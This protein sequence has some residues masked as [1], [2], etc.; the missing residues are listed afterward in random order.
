MPSFIRLETDERIL[1]FFD[2]TEPDELSALRVLE[3]I[4]LIALQHPYL[5][6]IQVYSRQHGV[7]STM[8][9][10][11]RNR[12]LDLRLGTMLVDTLNSPPH[13]Y[14]SRRV[15]FGESSE[16]ENLFSMVIGRRVRNGE[17]IRAIVIN[18][19]ADIIL[20]I[21]HPGRRVRDSEM[22]I[23]GPNKQVY[24][25]PDSSRFSG[26]FNAEEDVWPVI[27]ADNS[28]GSLSLE[29]DGVP[30]VVW[31]L[32]HAQLPWRFILYTPRR[33]LFAEIIRLR[34]F[35]L[36]LGLTVSVL[37]VFIALATVRRSARATILRLALRRLLEQYPDHS[38]EDAYV[39]E[40]MLLARATTWNV[41]VL[42]LDGSASSAQTSWVECRRFLDD[43]L[44]MK[45]GVNVQN[46]ISVRLDN[47]MYC[48]V[49]P[50]ERMQ[51]ENICLSLLEECRSRFRHSFSWNVTDFFSRAELT[52]EETIVDLLGQSVRTLRSVFRA[53][54]LFPGGSWLPEILQHAF[55]GIELSEID[56]QR[57]DKALRFDNG[58][59][60]FNCISGMLD[61]CYT[62]GNED[63]F[64]Y[65]MNALLYRIL[66][67]PVTQEL[68]G[69][70]GSIEEIRDAILHID[71]VP[72]ASE[73]FARYCEAVQNHKLDR[74][75]I[76]HREMHQKILDYIDS[77]FQNK[78]LGPDILAD[79]LGRSVAYIREIFKEIEGDSLSAVI[80]KKRIEYAC[81]LLR[82][83]ELSVREIADEAGFRNYSYFFTYF[84]KTTG[85][86]P[87]DYRIF[88]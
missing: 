69:E 48:M 74:T 35:L 9:G 68:T 21:L 27:I 59:E 85:K 18:V 31:W 45:G 20:E 11:E 46:S 44:L 30:S 22:M 76:K 52:G 7:I 57:L 19:S 61:N 81:S 5:H 23:V 3:V 4:D 58:E 55:E 66:Q 17:V 64:R 87:G 43:M 79:H 51:I 53:K 70:I 78:N 80:G 67:S 49:Y 28:E 15:Y 56:L 1:D 36:Y 47:S 72:E 24:Y 82:K 8:A 38:D 41:A 29:I 39:V 71:S 14:H 37:F 2:A 86:T 65:V 60:A 26:Y 13:V 12:M 73:Y 77:N 54:Y 16:A 63:S 34:W 6:S 88:E 84:K 33:E 10:W 40:Q 50:G 42:R 32:D 83:T 62:S 75:E 25:H